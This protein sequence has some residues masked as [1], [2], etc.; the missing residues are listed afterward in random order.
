MISLQGKLACVP[1]SN[2]E[3]AGENLLTSAQSNSSRKCEPTGTKVKNLKRKL[4]NP[5]IIELNNVLYS[6]NVAYNLL[7]AG[8][9]VES[10]LE[11]VLNQ[12]GGR[13]IDPNS[14]KVIMELHYK[15]RTWDVDLRPEMV[16]SVNSRSGKVGKAFTADEKKN[17]KVEPEGR[18]MVITKFQDLLLEESENNSNAGWDLTPNI[19]VRKDPGLKWHLRL[20]HAS[21]NYLTKMKEYCEELKNIKFDDSLKDCFVC[22]QAKLKRK[23]CKKIR[24]RADLP[25]YR[26]HADTMGPIATKAF[27]TRRKF[28]LV[29]V[30]D[31]SRYAMVYAMQNKSDVG[32][33]FRDYIVL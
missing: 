29:L 30:D 9:L 32:S 23:P 27:K 21:V 17:E 25:F 8:R 12:K 33:C 26:V 6:Q 5:V 22:Q 14:G 10:G 20:A 16:D 11:I 7:S 24:E 15:N 13:V 31:Y 4:L 2:Q 1:I 18:E 19:N 3:T 28:V